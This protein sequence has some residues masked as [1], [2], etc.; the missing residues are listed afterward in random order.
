M[1]NYGKLIESIDLAIV[2][3]FGYLNKLIYTDIIKHLID[4]EYPI[5]IENLDDLKCLNVSENP[6]NIE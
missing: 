2:N 1:K 4:I 6:N 5:E 3:V